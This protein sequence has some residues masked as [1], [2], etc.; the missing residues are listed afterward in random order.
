MITSSSSPRQVR[1]H[2]QHRDTKEAKQSAASKYIV[3]R[4]TGISYTLIDDYSSS[5]FISESHPILSESDK[6]V[7]LVQKQ[8]NR[9]AKSYIVGAILYL[10]DESN[11]IASKN[12]E[13][14]YCRGQINEH[15]CN[16][17]N[18]FLLVRLFWTVKNTKAYLKRYPLKL[19][20]ETICREEIN[21]VFYK[22]ESIA[23]Q[24]FKLD[25][26]GEP[27][28]PLA[29]KEL[30][31]RQKLKDE[32]IGLEQDQRIEK[33]RA[34]RVKTD[35]VSARR[36][37][38]AETM[39]LVEQLQA[40]D[41]KA[42][43]NPSD[44]YKKAKKILDNYLVVDQKI[45]DRILTLYRELHSKAIGYMII[46]RDGVMDKSFILL[47]RVMESNNAPIEIE[48]VEF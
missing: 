20:L 43:D 6:I 14:K 12:Q 45:R 42:L 29:T 25:E 21:A 46:P 36:R 10:L 35:F 34:A 22:I 41:T 48:E 37:I 47:I 33:D 11:L 13:S 2:K 39:K 16:T 7:R 5:Y 38:K 26:S 15:L 28:L 4:H 30:K 19:N 8:G 3:C 27:F 24:E 31:A 1:Q 32:L 40:K 9:V 18:A 44:S 23:N 17:Y